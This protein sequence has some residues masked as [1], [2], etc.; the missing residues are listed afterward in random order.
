MLRLNSI[1]IA[2]CMLLI[3][4]SISAVDYLSYGFTRIN[5]AVVTVAAFT[6]L[7]LLNSASTRARDRA[8][9]GQDIADL[10]RGTSNLG[11]KIADFERRVE[12]VKTTLESGGDKSRAVANPLA[13]EIK[14]NGAY[15]DAILDR[16]VHNA[17][18]INLTGRSLRR[19][20]ASKPFKD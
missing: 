5:V 4:G 14:P 9:I 13:A 20:R 15:A 18:R 16:I 11:R 19:S 10:S 1:F 3:A 12:L 6:A 17:H 7:A 8:D 2:I